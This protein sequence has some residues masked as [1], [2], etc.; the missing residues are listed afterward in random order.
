MNIIVS[1]PSV[2]MVL[3]VQSMTPEY[4]L[5]MRPCF[6]ISAWFW[7]RSFTLSMG[8][9]AVFEMTAAAPERAKFSAKLNFCPF[10]I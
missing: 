8:A 7:T 4:G 6:N 3:V 10:A 9:A 1:S 5:S 2:F